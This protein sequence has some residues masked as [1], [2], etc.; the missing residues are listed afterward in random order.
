MR[1]ILARGGI[2][3]LAV[4]LGITA[5]LWIDKNQKQSDLEQERISVYKIISNEISQIIEYTDVR[6][7]F[8][9]KQKEKI[10]Y[11][12]DNW[13]TFNSNEIDDPYKFTYDIWT[14]GTYMYSPNFSTFE[15]LKSNGQF[16]LVDK[17][18]R[19]KFGDLF[20]LMSYIKKIENN[21]NEAREKLL[22]Y[23]AR[24]H[25]E[26]QYQYS[27]SNPGTK[28]KFENFLIVLEKLFFSAIADITLILSSLD[29]VG[30]KIISLK[31]RLTFSNLLRFC[32]SSSTLFSSEFSLDI[33]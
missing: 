3:F 25:S 13:E 21:E 23:I 4:L 22:T 24:N 29:T 32:I 9:E 27:Y 15:A 5:S 7:E 1:N 26:I 14:T 18:I 11:L 8:Y 20:M 30:F 28:D 33:S 19:K 2:E 10:D 31:S 6:L 16:N 12:F 17:E